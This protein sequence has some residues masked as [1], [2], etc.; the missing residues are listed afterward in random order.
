MFETWAY[1]NL[2]SVSK[3]NIARRIFPVL[4]LL[5]SELLSFNVNRLLNDDSYE[6]GE[7]LGI[8][9][10]RNVIPEI[11]N[12]VEN[13]IPEIQ[14]NVENVIPEIQNNVEN[15]I[16]EIQNNVENVI[17]EI[18]NNVETVLLFF[19]DVFIQTAGER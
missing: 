1:T 19:P 17:P 3:L 15:V 11:Q 8:L 18:Q 14:N 12:N 13:V 9:L 6:A 7:I 16:P 2:T 4:P 10:E 5:D